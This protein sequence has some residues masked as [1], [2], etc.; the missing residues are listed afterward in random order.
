MK[1]PRGVV[2]NVMDCD[3]VGSEFEL[4]SRYYVHLLTNI[5]GARMTQPL[6]PPDRNEIVPTLFIYKDG[7]CI[8]SSS[9]RA[10][11]MDFPD[12]L[13]PPVPI[14]HRSR[15]VFYATSCISTELL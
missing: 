6:Y 7:V 9:W 10:A 3:I 13:P 1:N 15:Q 4:Y 12:P 5:L 2:A 8:K 11:S 14:V